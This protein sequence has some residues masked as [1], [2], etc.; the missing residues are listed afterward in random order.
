MKLGLYLMTSKGLAVL[1]T[2]LANDAEI[3]HITTWNARGMGDESH[4]QIQELG[5]KAGI[6]TFGRQQP[7]QIKSDWSIAVGWRWMIDNPHLIVIHDSLLPRYRGFSPMVTALVQGEREIGAT[8]FWARPDMP[9]DTGPIVSQR[10]LTLTYPIRAKDVIKKLEP[11]YVDLA[12]DVY[13][14][15]I[16]RGQVFTVEQ[17]E[18]FA[19]Y[20]LF[21]DETDYRISWSKD[22]HA[23]KRLV[24]AVSDPFPGAWTK[25]SHQS[26]LLPT[27]DQ[28]WVDDCSVF[29]DVRIEDRQPGKTFGIQDG[30]PIIVCGNGLLRVTAMRTGSKADIDAL[31]WSLM[32][33]RF[34]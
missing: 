25:L 21:R 23:I 16:D 6:P 1:E 10:T 24:D 17:D 30:D 27:G 29:P 19:S 5:K 28:F 18:A 2:L 3:A 31:P 32:K 26:A 20:S 11:L 22:A 7:P 15:L 12:F 4:L 8:A 14:Q 34:L 13:T 9:P 33:A